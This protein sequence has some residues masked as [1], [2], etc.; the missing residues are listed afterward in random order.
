MSIYRTIGPLV[1]LFDREC[2]LKDVLVLPLHWLL[3]NR[4]TQKH[5][6]L[7]N[8]YCICLQ[9]V[10]SERCAS[11]T[12]ALA[13]GK[14]ATQKHHPLTNPYCICLQGVE[15]ERCAS[16]T[17]V[18]AAGKPDYTETSSTDKP[19]LYLFTGSGVREMC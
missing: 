2:S 15:S 6:P 14:P 13:A 1:L 18:L 7:T 10:E 17:A 11:F 19:L 5:P 12:A 9:R 3:G 4:S 8:L 16:F